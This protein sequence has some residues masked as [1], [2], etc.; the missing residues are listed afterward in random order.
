MPFSYLGRASTQLVISHPFLF[1]SL[2]GYPNENT[3]RNVADVCS[4][5]PCHAHF[6]HIWLENDDSHMCYSAMMERPIAQT[7]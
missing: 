7:F 1:E 4:G 3:K 5:V 2:T 6:L